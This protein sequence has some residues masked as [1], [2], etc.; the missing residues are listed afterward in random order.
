MPKN[1][2]LMVADDLGRQTLG[3]YGNKAVKT[4]HLDKFAS[5]G[6]LFDMAF[7]ST[8]SCSASRSVI[9]TG[10]HAHE[11][12]QYGLNHAH[13]HFVTFDHIETAPKLLGDLG[14]LTA[15]VGKVHVGPRSVYSW[16]VYESNMTRNV[17]WVADR[18]DALFATAKQTERP[19]FLTVGFVDPHRDLTRSGFGND[20]SYHGVQDTT[21]DTSS[22]T[23]PSFLS[24]LEGVREELAEYYRSIYRLDQGVGMVL[25]ALQRNG[26]A[27]DTLVVFVSDNGPPFIN[28]ND[29]F[30]SRRQITY[31]CPS[32]RKSTWSYQS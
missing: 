28:S 14:Y 19:F 5:E 1:I 12:G 20:E 8:A 24:N 17:A 22:V 7:T 31:A 16:E 11:N 2:L 18:A 15:I 6:A 3:C 25:A 13:H 29:T 23:V 10:L 30:R 27:D 4:P 9:Y 26:L 32:T 21:F